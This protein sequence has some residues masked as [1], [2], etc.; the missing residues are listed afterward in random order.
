[1]MRIA[2]FFLL[3]LLTLAPAGEARDLSKIIAPTRDFSKPEPYELNQGGAGTSRQPVN[4]NAF[5]H[6]S[7]NIGFEQ[8][9]DFFVGNGFFKR[10]W[11][12]APGGARHDRARPAG[13]DRRG[14]H[15]VSRRP[16]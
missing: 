14:R 8:R 5:S 10:L 12:T 13:G 16:R 9:A 2:W 6:P 7:A 15:P 4:G 11:V 3:S 1:M